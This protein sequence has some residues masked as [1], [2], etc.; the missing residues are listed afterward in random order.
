MNQM[1]TTTK[2]VKERPI[3]FSGAMVRAILEGRKTMTRRV[4]KNTLGVCDACFSK[5]VPHNYG[6]GWKDICS[7]EEFRPYL[8]VPYCEHNEM[9]GCRPRSPWGIGDHLWVRETWGPRIEDGKPHPVQQYV[10]YRAD[11][12]DDSPPADGMDW[13]SY[14]NKWRPSL[15]MPRWASRI[16][17]EIT[18]VR[19]ERLRDIG[20]DG[21]KLT[22]YWQKVLPEKPS[23][24]TRN[25]FTQT[26]RQH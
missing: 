8:R 21:R 12:A 6:D 14:E 20:K 10:K 2:A 4:V 17:L 19:V 25:G 22:T 1:S 9:C 16:T 3:L 7:R 13:H 11:F 18:D 26:M 5:G 15:H 24:T 23:S